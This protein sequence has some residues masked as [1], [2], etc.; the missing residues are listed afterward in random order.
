M[1][2]Y[3]LNLKLFYSTKINNHNYLSGFGTRFLGDG[4]NPDKI[5]NFLNQSKIDYQTLVVAQ[6]THSANIALYQSKKSL[7]LKKID[8]VDG[9]ITDKKRVVL[10][11]RTAD[12]LPAVFVDKKNDLVGISHQGWAGTLK[13]LIQKMIK[14]MI[15]MGSR[16]KDIFIALGPSIGG[17]C[18]HIDKNRYSLFLKEFNRYSDKIFN[19]YRGKPYLNLPFLNYLLLVEIG[20]PKENI[21]FFPFCTQ[22]DKNHFFSF[23][24]D[25]KEDYG[26]MFSFVL[27]T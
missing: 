18:Y 14:K 22:C 26:E 20:I 3:D 5:V 11:V 1:L 2:I 23:R 24:R 17:C 19:F 9:L 12:C 13:G 27:R 7:S 10:V 21:D 6:Q 4:R 16:K 25:R 8:T 15:K